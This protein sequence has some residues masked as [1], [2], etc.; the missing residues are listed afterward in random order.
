[1]TRNSLGVLAVVGLAQLGIGCSGT[2]GF[3]ARA[4]SADASTDACLPARPE[5]RASTLRWSAEER[6]RF[7][8]DARSGGV[9]VRAEGCN[10]VILPSCKVASSYEYH[11]RALRRERRDQGSEFGVGVSGSAGAA[12]GVN[13]DGSATRDVV[14]AGGFELPRLPTTADLVGAC[15]GATHVVAGYATGAFR[16][17]GGQSRSA[18]VHVPYAGQ[19]ASNEWSSSVQQAGRL[20]SC[21]QRSDNGSAPPVDCSATISL[22]VVPLGQPAARP[23]EPTPAVAQQLP[24]HHGSATVPV[25]ACQGGDLTACDAECRS[26]ILAGCNALAAHCAA[27]ALGACV[28]ASTA[29]LNHWLYAGR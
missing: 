3:S 29:S 25:D 1:M 5:F 14:V 27:G 26:G 15:A 9:V 16:I 13:R 2:I 24:E 6:E 20:E 7:A 10:W 4:S 12:P 8:R 22:D 11:A 21:E 28:A 23:P 17:S 19:V 18:G